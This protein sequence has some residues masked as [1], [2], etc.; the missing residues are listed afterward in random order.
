MISK[1]ALR[2]ILL[3]LTICAITPV[4][5]LFPATALWSQ[6]S[7]APPAP[8][9]REAEVC[10]VKCEPSGVDAITTLMTRRSIRK[11][12]QEPVSE[13]LLKVLL[14]AA[15]NAPSAG[16]EQPWEFII[17]RDRK[18]LAQIPTFHPYSRHVKDAPM[19]IL[20]SGNLK[21]EKFKGNWPLDCANASMSILIAAHAS[22]LGAVWTGIYPEQERMAGM[23]KLLN[24]PDHVMP[25]ALIPMGFPA[26][27]KEKAYRFDSA[28]V[29]YDRW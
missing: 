4:F 29:H 23:R 12:T 25:F 17:I 10:E 26:E 14:E 13:E 8:A 5:V 28:R 22:G 16:N 18:L 3:T 6:Q 1:G 27:K 9:P 19:A 20:V 21:R 7:A 24:I 2:A 15:M 11:Y